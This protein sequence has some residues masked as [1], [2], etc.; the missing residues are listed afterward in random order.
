MR[1]PG[2]FRTLRLEDWAS[3]S[4]SWGRL[5]NFPCWIPSSSNELG[6][7]LL[8]VGVV[9]ARQYQMHHHSSL[10]FFSVRVQRCGSF[11]VV[12][13]NY[14][15]FRFVVFSHDFHVPGDY[16]LL[17]FCHFQTFL[18]VFLMTSQKVERVYW[19]FSFFY[20]L[21]IV[22]STRNWKDAASQSCV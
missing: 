12:E 10:D 1:I 15:E 21:F 9:V 7:L 3:R 8:K 19:V 20:R 6:L 11:C 13:P 22:R 16:I 4:E 14:C 18:S 17:K 2:I 5:S